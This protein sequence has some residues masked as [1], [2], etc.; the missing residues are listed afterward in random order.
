MAF[1]NHSKLY[2]LIKKNLILMKRNIIL[3]ILE[4]FFPII[5]MLIIIGIRKA[6]SIES[7]KFEE[8]EINTENFIKKNSIVSI[9][10]EKLS[11]N[12]WL[13]MEVL[14]PL[15]ICSKYNN[16]FQE[17]PKIA[18]IGIPLEIKN[19]MI[20]DS[21]I[22]KNIINFSLNENSFKEF[23]SIEEMENYIK[24]PE[25]ITDLDNLICFGLKFSYDIEKKCYNYSLHFFDNK[26]GKEGIQDIPNNGEGMFETFQMGPDLTSYSIYKN[27]AY[28]Y[29][30]KI[31]NEYIL[32]KELND[33][34]AELNYAIIP[35]KYKEFKIDNFGEYI[36]YVITII[37]VIAYMAPLSL[38]IYR[39]VGEKET[40]I[41]ETMKI[42]GLTEIEYFLSYFIQ[43][44]IISLLVSLINSFLLNLVFKHIPLHFLYFIF[45]L[46]S[47]DVFALI[48]FFQSFIDKKRN[49]LLLSLAIYF[50]MYCISLLC[51]FEKRSFIL[52]LILSLF[53][54]V[55]LNIGIILLSKFEY[56]FRNFQNKDFLVYYG[57]YSIGIMYLMFIIDFFLYLFLGY[58]LYNVI[59]HDF[60]LRK[61]WYFLCTKNYWFRKKINK[62][63]LIKNN[64]IK[65]NLNNSKSVYKN[66]L[67]EKSDLSK[68]NLNSSNFENEEIYTNKH[69]NGEVLKI[70]NIVKVFG[71]GKRA[72]DGISLNLYKDEIFALLGQN[73]AGK[74]TLISILTGIYEVTSGLAIYNNINILES[75]NMD[76]FRKKLGICPQHDI[77]YDNLNIREHLEMFS[78]F[79]GVNSKKINI[80]V[81]KMIKDFKL[82]KNQYIL[83]KNLSAGQRRKLSIAMA[84]IGGSE[85]IFLDE[86]SSGTDITSR[87]DLWDI[88]KHQTKGKIIIL[89]THY[90]EEASVLGNRIGI[91]NLGKMKCL[92]TPLFLIEKFGKYMNLN[93]IKEEKAND[94]K[95]IDFILNFTKKIKYEVLSEEIL[96]RIQ[97]REDYQNN[98]TIKKFNLSNFFENFDENLK[99]LKIKSYNVSMPT[100]EDVFLNISSS[101]FK[102]SLEIKNQVTIEDN[103]DNILFSCNLKE[104]YSSIKKFI[105]DFSICMKRRFIITVRDIK[106]FIMEI[107]CPIILIL[108]G[109]GISKTQLTF[110]SY[111]SEINIEIIGKQYII[112]SSIVNNRAEEYFINDL[113]NVTSS[114]KDITFKTNIKEEII[115]NFV[116]EMYDI[117][118]YTEEEQ[119]SYQNEKYIGYYSSLLI[120]EEDNNKYDFII[121]LNSKIKHC[122]PLYSHYLLKAIIEKVVEHQVNI[123]FTHYPFPLTYDIKDINI[124]GN[125][126]TIMFFVGIS[127]SLQ[128]LNFISLLVRERINNSKHLMRISGINIFSYWLVNYT[129][130]LLKYYLTF[131]ICILLLYIFNFYK[132]YLYIFYL[133]Y[134]PGM[135]SL[136]Y[137]LTFFIST[138]SN[139]QNIIILLNFVFGN[140]GSIIIILLRGNES[141]KT[142]AKIL[143]YILALNPIFCFNFSFNLLIFNI[144]IY[145]LDYPISWIFFKGDE[146]I[147]KFNLLLSMIIFASIECVFYTILLIL[148][149]I[150]SSSFRK[151]NIHKSKKLENKNKKMNDKSLYNNKNEKKEHSKI[152]NKAHNPFESVLLQVKNLKKIYRNGCCNPKKNIIIA[153]N[154]LNF[155]VKHGECFGLLGLNGAGKTTTFKCITQEISKNDGD[156]LVNG[157]D[158]NEKFDELNDLF[159]YCPQF[160]AI[161]EHLTV[162]ENLEFYAR[163]KGINKNSIKT[164]VKTLI[165]QMSLKEFKYKVSNHLSGGNKRKLAVAISI[166]CNP[167]IIFLD[168]PCTGIDPEARKS[169]WSIIHKIYTKSRASVVLTTHSMEEAEFLCKRIGIMINGE[170]AYLGNPNKLKEKYGNGY[171][172]NISIKP[173]SDK[174]KKILLKNIDEN[175]MVDKKNIS[176]ILKH[177]NKINFFN[178]IKEG[179]LGEKINREIMINNTINISELINWIYFIENALR[180]IVKGKIYF[181]KIILIENFENHFLFKIIKNNEK[182]VGF[183]FGL[184][185]KIK[186]E[187]FVS[188]YSIQ[189]TSL[190]QIFIKLNNNKENKTD[191]KG[192]IIDDILIQNLIEKKENESV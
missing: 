71:D 14:P 157:R 160:N 74:T 117:M 190:E 110:K 178:E 67:E 56:H 23:A 132:K 86:P 21:L 70:K 89:T 192:I 62:F 187:C 29:M 19:K 42:M 101:D 5:M 124:I 181:E 10:F 40:K 95:I 150:N 41:K 32:E 93:I 104:H 55:C 44:F 57:N 156:I 159:G 102:K 27:S 166:I 3:T 135:I 152:V 148:I 59:L 155:S 167:P 109:L 63:Q 60:G 77:L 22:F 165:N 64:Q 76:L 177:L 137:S 186:E 141:S 75:M 45:L 24:T 34:S 180:F 35:M 91:I 98:R 72:I 1:I 16:Q 144:S 80:E 158:I 66:I 191:N 94:K 131:G 97:I 153:V 78:T 54:S 189:Q 168:E 47:L 84:L 128:P 33:N 129:F 161:F 18:S 90:M 36:A 176:D 15:K 142:L 96:F 2:A 171:E 50:V 4:I 130:E 81:N 185:E 43:Y 119:N 48:Y 100:L 122:I 175:T 140:L 149:E 115:K 65:K 9:N 174:M 179:R 112:F 87:R 11:S 85:V 170:L 133:L 125:K 183:L 92:G 73:G 103:N 146:I 38:Y 58:Y 31:V 147:K 52:K 188:E 26:L 184:F 49:A 151:K 108:I 107:L 173:I 13:G 20:K 162:Y 46:W 121:L 138:E 106:G 127:F 164:L 163:I 134:G 28:S 6:F 182:T 30:I 105:N 37:I 154:N 17:R 39:I 7:Y 68:I 116:D 139:A 113:K 69:I 118:K 123:N 51:L 114:K 61:P 83:S 99:E 25:Y 111:P 143:E 88:L 53:P 8:K 79:K 145:T 169:M 126:L 82:E 120:L 12:I 136:T 172:I